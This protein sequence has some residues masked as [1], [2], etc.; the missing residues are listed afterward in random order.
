MI[1]TYIISTSWKCRD[2]K[3][4]QS[5]LL[6]HRSTLWV[7]SGQ[8]HHVQRFNPRDGG[9]IPGFIPI[10][11]R[12]NHSSSSQFFVLSLKSQ[13]Y[14]LILVIF[15]IDIP[16]SFSPSISNFWI[17]I[18]VPFF[19]DEPLWHVQPVRMAHAAQKLDPSGDRDRGDV[20]LVK[21]TSTGRWWSGWWFGTWPLW[22]SI[23]WE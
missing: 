14:P 11:S 1:Y 22:F 2:E 17:S 20:G 8:I 3:A 16:C 13:W 21:R 12:K 18:W 7:E 9:Y 4:F 19:Q 23:Y 6:K 15:Q 10:L 5:S